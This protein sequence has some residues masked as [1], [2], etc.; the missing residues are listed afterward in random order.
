MSCRRDFVG[1]LLDSLLKCP[2]VGDASA[3]WLFPIQEAANMLAQQ[4]DPKQPE[5]VR[6]A[7]RSPGEG[8]QSGDR[9]LQHHAHWLRARAPTYN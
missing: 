4:P 1:G 5:G 9:L 3:A 2:S 7:T 8:P 6:V